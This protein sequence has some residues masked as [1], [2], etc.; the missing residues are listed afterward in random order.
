MDNIL[1]DNK[2][3]KFLFLDQYG[4]KHIN[5]KVF[6]TLINSILSKAYT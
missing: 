2:K 5:E 1:N 3:A 4:I 6:K